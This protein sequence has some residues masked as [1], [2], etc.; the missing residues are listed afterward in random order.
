MEKGFIRLKVEKGKRA[1]GVQVQYLTEVLRGTKNLTCTYN[2]SY[3][4][5]RYLIRLPRIYLKYQEYY[6]GIRRLTEAPESSRDAKSLIRA[7][8]VLHRY[9]EFKI[10]GVFSR[11]QESYPS[12]KSLTHVPGAFLMY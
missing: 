10:Q 8:T 7:Q 11:F 2:K 1:Q 4:D 5:I 6:P 9:K 3:P 12:D